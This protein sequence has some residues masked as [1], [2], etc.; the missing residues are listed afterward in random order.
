ML[1][2]LHQF[3]TLSVIPLS[4]VKCSFVCFGI[5]NTCVKLTKVVRFKM[6]ALRVNMHYSTME[7]TELV[8]NEGLDLKDFF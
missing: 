5:C 8:L 2:Q 4:P 1:H 6:A 7:A 3:Q